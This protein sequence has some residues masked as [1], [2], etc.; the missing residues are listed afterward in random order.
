MVR[1]NDKIPSS[2]PAV[3]ALRA[4]RGRGAGQRHPA[5]RRPRRAPERRLGQ[6]PVQVLV[7]AVR[8]RRRVRLGFGRIV[9]SE[10]QVPIILVS[11]V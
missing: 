1:E 10:R 4:H 5:V 8:L 6:G 7:V 9:A 2:K 3:A 11:M